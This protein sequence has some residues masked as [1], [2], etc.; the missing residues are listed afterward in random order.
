L[1]ESGFNRMIKM[2]QAV[3]GLN[4]SGDDWS[5]LFNK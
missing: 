4:Q 2:S 5:V 1:D 3:A